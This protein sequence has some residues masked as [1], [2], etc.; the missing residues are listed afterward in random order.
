MIF[1]V[2]STPWLL[3]HELRLAR[4]SL[5][6]ARGMRWRTPI[7]GVAFLVT[8]AF[9]GVP[10]A[11]ALQRFGLPRTPL[12][13]LLA[14]L[15]TLAVFTLM[16][17]QS[18][19]AA[20]ETLYSRA[21]L[22]LLLSSPIA[23][24]KV[25]FA[26]CAGIAANAFL[27]FAILVTPLAVPVAVL[28]APRWLAIYV[29][30]AALAL[31][32]TALGLGAAIGLF[33]L[34]GP[35]RTRTISQLLA[36]LIG[37]GLFLV[38]QG[39]NL[40]GQ[41]RVVH[42][43]GGF[44]RSVGR[45]QGISG[46]LSWPLRAVDGDPAVLAVLAAV[47]GASF[48]AV[49]LWVGRRFGSDAAAAGGAAVGEGPRRGGE[50]AFAAGVFRVTVRKELRL[51]GRDIPLLAQVL[52]RV[53]YLLP[54]I[55]LLL[56]NAGGDGGAMRL[57][58][59]VGAVVFV[60]GQVAGSLVWLTVCAE[61]A[62]ELIGCAPASAAAV[63]RAKLCA[64]LAPLAAL[65]IVPLLALLVLAP[66]AGVAAMAGCSAAALCGALI[67]FALQKPAKRS[68]FRR[69][70]SGSLVASIVEFA[71]AAAVAAASGAAVAWPPLLTLPLLVAGLAAW[72]IWRTDGP[73]PYPLPKARAVVH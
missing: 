20:T 35:R 14:A 13:G 23:P 51:L 1:A 47:A 5:F 69:R 26:K 6:A 37:A 9:V 18:L 10:A 36:V 40:V 34:I 22:D 64:A 41:E 15:G 30:L 59:G 53:L 67:G 38:A 52:L 44:M 25:L 32:A 55:F 61:D 49:T 3:F 8:G 43:M 65:M 46:P 4:R 24:G 71:A 48:A 63:R 28:A 57:P 45:G 56:R 11:I 29:V 21:D 66:L 72:T 27:S 73:P 68:A 54:L 50:G 17:S 31:L 16:L 19:A 58:I 2:Q 70:R 62:P 42:W 12:V 33:R 39:R 60:C 7:I